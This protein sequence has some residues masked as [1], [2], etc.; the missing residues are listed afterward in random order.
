[1]LASFHG[2][3]GGLATQPIL[4][5]LQTICMELGTEQ[6]PL[7]LIVGIDANTYYKAVPNKKY[8]V[9]ELMEWI[10]K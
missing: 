7:G 9:D 2:D 5:A 1:M 3:T 8:G 6:L 4:D 10:K